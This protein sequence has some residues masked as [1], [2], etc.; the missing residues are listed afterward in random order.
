MLTVILIMLAGIVLGYFL[1]SKPQLIKVLNKS[2]IWVIFI[3]LLFMGVSVGS[4][5]EVVNNLDTIGL[6]GLQLAIV[7]ILGSVLLSWVAY[8]WVFKTKRAD[9]EG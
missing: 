1:R 6:R 2:T 7:T 3:L 9:N 8:L 5:S 4:N